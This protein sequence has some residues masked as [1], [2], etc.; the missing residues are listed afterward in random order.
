V[1]PDDNLV[2]RIRE[3]GADAVTTLNTILKNRD[4]MHHRIELEV[5]SATEV[6][7]AMAFAWPVDSLKRAIAEKGQ[8]G[9]SF[10]ELID[11]IIIKNES[12]AKLKTTVSA[13]DADLVGEPNPPAD[14]PASLSEVA[15]LKAELDAIRKK[16]PAK[17]KKKNNNN[18][19]PNNGG[20]GR[21]A[22]RGAGRNAGTSRP[23]PLM[24]IAGQPNVSS[25]DQPC[26]CGSWHP[27]FACPAWSGNEWAA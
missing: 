16:L 3:G 20:A 22:R 26:A 9:L 15:A 12:S 5:R 11:L 21:G 2:A 27:G 19:G 7:R 13:I 17:K 1:T 8:D 6:T 10:E 23:R 24:S 4:K 25:V 18:N 14:A